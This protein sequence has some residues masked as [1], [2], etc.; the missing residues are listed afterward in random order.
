MRSAHTDISMTLRRSDFIVSSPAIARALELALKAAPSQEP[1]LIYGE[2]GTGKGML[3]EWIHQRSQRE[4]AFVSVNCSTFNPN[5]FESHLFG[6]VKGAFTGADKDTSGLFEAAEGGTLFLDEIADTPLEVQPRLLRAIEEKLVR[7]VGSSKEIAIDVR[8]VCATNKDLKAE[9]AKGKFREDL[10]YRINAFIV[11]LPPL[12]ERV[13]DVEQLANHFLTAIAEEHQQA[14]K[15]LEPEALA[16]IRSYGWPGN[17]RELRSAMAYAVASAG[18]R[19]TIARRDLPPPLD[20]GTAVTPPPP[21]RSES[22]HVR[23]FR[24]IYTQSP[25]DRH[26]WAL[27]LLSWQ[28]V[29]GNVRFSRRDMVEVMRAVRGPDPT[30]NALANEWQRRIKP[31]AV[32]LGLIT[33]DAKKLIIELERCRAVLQSGPLSEVTEPDEARPT[34]RVMPS[35][36]RSSS[37]RLKRTNLPP[38]RTSFV[39]RSR[40]IND[41]MAQLA[42]GP[43]ITTLLGPGG[44]GKTR[45][46]QEV[47][48]Q[49]LDRLHGGVWFADLTET[50]NVEGVAYAV[51][52]ALRVP[53]T[54]SEPPESAIASILESRGDSLLILDNFEQVVDAAKATVATWAQRAPRTR[55]LV[56]SRALLGVEGERV[57]ELKPLTFPA[58]KAS[59]SLTRAQLEE[60]DAVQLFVDRARLANLSFN[61]DDRNAASV[62][63]ICSILEGMPLAIELAAA[64]VSIMKPEQMLLRLDQKFDFLR[65]TRRDLSERQRSLMATIDWSYHLLTPVE[66]QAFAQTSLFRDGFFLEAAERVLHLAAGRD[67]PAVIDLIQSLRDKSLLRSWDTSS[68]TRFGCYDTMAEYARLKLADWAGS[69]EM[70]KLSLQH[71]EYYLTY[72]EQWDKRIFSRSALEALDRLELERENLLAAQGALI[73]AIARSTPEGRR[74]LEGLLCRVAFV[75]AHL[76]RIRGP[77]HLRQP[78]LARALEAMSR[79]DSE[80]RAR[81]LALDSIVTGESG[82]SKR[83]MQLAQEALSLAQRLGAARVRVQA[84]NQ[85]AWL[86][87]AA[88]DNQKALPLYEEVLAGFR[89]IGDVHNEARVLGRLGQIHSRLGNQD[90]GVELLAQS[91]AMLEELGDRIGQAFQFVTRA[92][93][94][95]RAGKYREGLEA[96]ERAEKLFR[97]FGDKR[98]TSHALGNRALMLKLMRDYEGALRVSDEC[99]AL[100]REV[101]DFNTFATDLANRGHLLV[102][103]DRHDE[104]LAAFEE[105]EKY[106]SRLNNPMLVSVCREMRA[107]ILWHHGRAAEAEKLFA[108]AEQALNQRDA[109]ALASIKVSRG[110]CLVDSGRAAEALGPLREAIGLLRSRGL[111][112]DRDFF[113]AVVAL[114]RCESAVGRASDAVVLAREGLELAQKLGYTASDPALRVRRNL[115]DLERLSHPDTHS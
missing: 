22:E 30:D 113:K 95:H 85:V 84:Q 7:R 65:T 34:V 83:A 36:K 15:P 24:R 97:E 4:G 66:Q 28:Q 33:E 29:L 35:A 21:T 74:R 2:T 32:E 14:A 52:Q 93:I 11:H 77:S 37:N 10:F 55:L 39:G 5:L 114:A 9:I 6:Y 1:V 69:E 50:R 111:T 47:G 107:W 20:G 54:T 64:R 41:L 86:T 43:G 91:A 23:L 31:I 38:P 79:D 110:E 63:E 88:G 87:F 104:A 16:A 94:L 61:L 89:E 18:S 57:M 48:W 78:V 51:A 106:H 73:A 105:S 26:A 60:F 67:V 108:E 81:M 3:A 12:R 58:H 17:I 109:A 112:G 75:L 45:L 62:G 44:T 46:A 59:A 100:A 19:A 80:D 92:N 25:T 27:F 115:L 68:E 96:S 13:E 102:D 103:L 40:E 49:L 82:D 72:C 56:T 42:A 8:L 99:R 90:K 71:A 53:L 98:S 76:L 70:Q 101:G